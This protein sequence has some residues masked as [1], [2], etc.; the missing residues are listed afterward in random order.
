MKSVQECIE[1]IRS[2]LIESD[3]DESQMIVDGNSI[4][5]YVDDI[6]YSAYVRDWRD[7]EFRVVCIDSIGLP[8]RFWTFT[9]ERG[10]YTNISDFWE[11]VVKTK[12]YEIVKTIWNTLLDLD[13]LED[14]S[15]M[16]VFRNIAAEYFDFDNS[17]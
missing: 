11:S 4:I 9:I 15:E 7:V 16:N 3:V 10:N 6:K 5:F 14:S 2:F 8:M 1:Y 12:R 17:F 13:K